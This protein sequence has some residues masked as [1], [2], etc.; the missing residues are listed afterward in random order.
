[1][2]TNQQEQVHKENQG[3]STPVKTQKQ[4]MESSTEEKEMSRIE[5]QAF[6]LQIKST[7][8]IGDNGCNQ[9]FFN[10]YPSIMNSSIVI[11]PDTIN[12]CRPLEMLPKLLLINCKY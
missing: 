12:G 6:L 8:D 7:C 3:L 1:V 4:K 10:S 5:F 9:I 2:P 11:I